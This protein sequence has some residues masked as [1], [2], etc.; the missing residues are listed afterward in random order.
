MFKRVKLYT[1]WKNECTLYTLNNIVRTKWGI[2]M[3]KSWIIDLISMAELAWIWSRDS[4]AIFKFIYNWYTWW[5]YKKIWV[6]INVKAYDI[7]TQEF[8]DAAN[9]GESFGIWLLYAS[10]WYRNTRADKEI[11]IQEVNEFKVDNNK[12]YWHNHM[13]KKW[14]IIDSLSSIEDEKKVI[15]FSLP[16]L[17]KAVQKWIY[18]QTARTLE[19]EDDLLNYYLVE[20]NKWTKF[21]HIEF[22]EDKSK[23]ALEKAIK[24]RWLY[25][26]S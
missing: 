9:H 19:M 7:L 20:L 16:A 10:N 1:Q 24:L 5:F 4:G 23:K 8:E 13:W 25:R 15:K 21:E 12:R 14:Y 18:W 6:Q 26:K 2:I 11:T 22:L 17:R 3:P